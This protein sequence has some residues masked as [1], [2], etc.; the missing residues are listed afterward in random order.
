MSIFRICRL[1]EKERGLGFVGRKLKGCVS[2]RTWE[3]YWHATM[4]TRRQLSIKL[5]GQGKMEKHGEH[6]KTGRG[7][8]GNDGNI[9]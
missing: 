9:L 4:M 3:K 1:K 7:K 5:Q 6:S 2:L 8:C